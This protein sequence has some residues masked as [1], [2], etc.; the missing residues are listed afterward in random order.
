MQVKY[1]TK[2]L[3]VECAV[4][5]DDWNFN[6]QVSPAVGELPDL[7]MPVLFHMPHEHRHGKPAEL[8]IRCV[9]TIA[10][11]EDPLQPDFTHLV[12]DVPTPFFNQLPTVDIAIPEK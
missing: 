3:L 8:H 2:A 12:V 1:F 4:R 6:R 10:Q 11:R 9:I 5:A 7:R